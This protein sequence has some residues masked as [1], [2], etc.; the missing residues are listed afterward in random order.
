[1]V[2]LLDRQRGHG[3]HVARS[4][5]R[6]AS[7]VKRRRA[8]SR[9]DR[10]VYPLGESQRKQDRAQPLN[11]PGSQPEVSFDMKNPRSQHRTRR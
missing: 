8:Q 4:E 5:L 6:I 11:T 1:M 3:P 9:G 10:R 7:V 2:G